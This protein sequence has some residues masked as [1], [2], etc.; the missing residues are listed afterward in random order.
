MPEYI[1]SI[2]RTYFLTKTV[3][4]EV[5]CLMNKVNLPDID[6]V[7]RALDSGWTYIFDNLIDY[8][9]HTAAR[10]AVLEKI[11]GV[12]TSENKNSSA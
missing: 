9:K 1:S 6:L 10:L 8:C 7:I 4:K 3:S 2:H 12:G 5:S 11:R